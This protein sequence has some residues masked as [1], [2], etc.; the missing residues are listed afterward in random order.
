MKFEEVIFTQKAYHHKPTFLPTRATA[1]SAG[2]DFFLKE[3]ITIKPGKAVFQYTDVKCKLNR[4]E[5]LLLFVRSSIGIKKHLMLANGT[6]VIDADYYNN[7]D[8][9][10][11]IGLA[12]YNYGTEPVTL[13]EG[14]RV[15]QGVT[16]DYQIAENDN[17]M[18]NRSGGFG[19]TGR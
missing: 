18:G 11:N 1:K 3:D 17:A 10:G 9:D 12:L 7:P 6:G 2:H 14:T 19:S 8:N 5:V 15:M 16:V 13:A 4:D